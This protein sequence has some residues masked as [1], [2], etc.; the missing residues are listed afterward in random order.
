[1]VYFLKV[2]ITDPMMLVET[3]SAEGY[4]CAEEGGWLVGLP[5]EGLH[6]ELVE[7]TRFRGH[8]TLWGLGE[9]G[10]VKDPERRRRN[11]RATVRQTHALLAQPSA[12]CAA[13]RSPCPDFAPG[14]C[15][16]PARSSGVTLPPSCTN[17]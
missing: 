6:R 8:L 13:S 12:P 16:R 14:P 9:G 4:A 17:H 2:S 5:C 7:L 10:R 3:A 11:A 1:M 15:A